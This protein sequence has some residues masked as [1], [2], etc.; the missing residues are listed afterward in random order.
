MGVQIYLK[1][2][3]GDM[4]LLS[5]EEL[6]SLM[7]KKETPCVSIYMPTYPTTPEAKQNPIRFKNLIR[8]A[9]ERLKMSGLRASEVKRLLKSPKT[10]LKNSIFWQHQ[11]N[12][13]AAFISSEF[14]RHFCLPV[15]FKELLV[16]T[17]RF[18]IK[19]LLHFF[20]ND[21]HFYILALSQNEVRLFHAT[22]HMINEIQ[23]K[24]IP[25]SLAEAL[26]YDD[27]ERQLQFHTRT[28]GPSGE[29]AAIFHGYGVGIDDAKVNI[30]RYFYQIDHGL[31]DLVKEERAPV[32]L[33]GV[34][35]LLPIYKEANT[36]L[37]LMENGITGNPEGLK[38]EEL[39]RQAWDMVEP[40]FLKAQE[41]AAEQYR[42][43][44]G[45]E[46]TSNDLKEIIRAAYDGRIDL[47]FVAV[48]IQEWGTFDPY[49]LTIHLHQKAEPGDEDLL[50]FAAIH[51][52]LNGGTVFA[53]EP[54]QMPDQA[55]LAALFRYGQELH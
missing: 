24:G 22:R 41:R 42:Q 29:R 32:V 35:Y 54:E 36:F 5:K 4:D 20:S 46:R 19:P 49:K 3:I 45:S 7:Q 55:P 13:L 47:L 27:P 28:P 15:T 31:H 18:H 1:R 43:L 25:G 52:L 21:G 53:V 11:G 8:E 10:L 12:G 9:E 33:A 23:L 26:Q 30:L 6:R 38:P 14:F 37:N 50:D 44:S 39:H 34:E 51:T 48:G 17:D 16:V 40:Y 2:R